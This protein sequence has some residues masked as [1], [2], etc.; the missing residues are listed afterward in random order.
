ML[1]CAIS[2]AYRAVPTI[3]T[4]KLIS[5][6]KFIVFRF[7]IL[8]FTFHFQC[9]YFSEFNQTK[10]FTLRFCFCFSNSFL[11]LVTTLP[12]HD[13][14]QPRK[15]HKT[16]CW[17]TI[18]MLRYTNFF[19]LFGHLGHRDLLSCDYKTYLESLNTNFDAPIEI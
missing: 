18:G 3:V 11:I 2:S 6:K 14:H 1:Y 4:M 12:R 9:N 16:F 17:Y 19:Y 8:A 10:C 13:T 15:I 5:L 7:P